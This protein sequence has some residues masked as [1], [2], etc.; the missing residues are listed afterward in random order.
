MIILT[1][2]LTETP[3]EGCRKV[4]S[5]LSRR[6]K[7]ASPDVT[8]VSLGGE[9]PQADVQLPMNRLMLS[10]KLA[11]L[12]CRHKE[13]VLY[14]PTF[15]RMLPTAL[16]VFI[17]S[18]Y[19]R[20]RLQVLV[21]QAS[22]IGRLAGLLLKWSGAEMIALSEESRQA[23][24]WVIGRRARRLKTGV[25]TARFVPVD[26]TRRAELRRKYAIP[27]DKPVV[28]HVGHLNQGRNVAQLL[29]LGEEFHTVLVV[30]TLTKDEQDGELRKRLTESSNLTLIDTWQPHIEELYQLADAYLFPVVSRSSCI[31]VPLSALEAAACNVPVVTTA[32]GELRQLLGRPG[33][34]SLSDLSPE[35][36]NAALH[37]ALRDGRGGREAVL[38]YDWN[39]AVKVLLNGGAQADAAE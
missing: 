34:Y 13:P 25:D 20:Q 5:S 4:A 19:T 9:S 14:I 39:Q 18:R 35:T 21:A 2:C 10:V 28:L 3:D 29:S 15:S 1:N 37:A 6:I 33:F 30:S 7:A 12:L 23:F 26:D 24:A 16:R 8:V 11:R 36:V 22:P 17:L 32:Y 31:D 38:E 27:A